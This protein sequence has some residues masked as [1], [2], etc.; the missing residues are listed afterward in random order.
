MITQTG[1]R[2]TGRHALALFVGF[3]AVVFI[4]NGI[5]VWAATQSWWRW[6]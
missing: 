2:F 5:F 1:F 3:F 4:V 6:G